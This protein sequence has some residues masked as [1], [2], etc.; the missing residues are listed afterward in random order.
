[1]EW[2]SPTITKPPRGG[3]QGV[4]RNYFHDL[5]LLDAF[6]SSAF[7]LLNLDRRV[8]QKICPI[9]FNFTGDHI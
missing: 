6:F 4:S 9:N 2:K 5:V 1:M 8:R 7:N 3:G